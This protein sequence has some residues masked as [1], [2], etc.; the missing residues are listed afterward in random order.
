MKRREFLK[1]TGLGALGL[2][3]R[4]LAVGGQPM[5][6]KPTPQQ[7]AWQEAELT[8]FLTFGMNTFTNREWGEGT[9]DPS[10]FN[11]S[12]LDAGQWASVAKEAGL[13]YLILVAKHHDGLCLWPSEFTEHSVKASPWRGG[14]GD[15]VRELADACRHER[16]KMGIY[17][18][19]WD[20]NC[21]VYG[22]PAYNGH[23]KNQLTELLTNYGEIAEVWF[24]GACGEGPNGKK[25][26]Y[27][28][29]GYYDVIRKL[30]PSALIAICGPDIRWVGNEDG[31]ARETEWSVQ[32]ADPVYHKGI[33]GKVWWPAECDVSIR[34][35]WFWH[36]AE[37]DKVKSLDHLMDIY[38]KSVGRNSV[39][40]LNV[41]PNDRGLI[42]EPD[43][44]RL[45]EFRRGLDKTFADDLAKGK[46]AHA[47]STYP[48]SRASYAVDGKPDTHWSP[49]LT[50]GWLEVD[51]GKP[52]AFDV[53]MVQEQISEGQR[54]EEYRIEAQT[55]QGW[56]E[57]A[58]GTTIGHKKLD[59][60]SPVT[61]TRVRLT[62]IRSQAKPLIRRLGLFKR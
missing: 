55:D 2:M 50:S 11:P 26:E 14:N 40:L 21:P 46:K 41:P 34:P 13:K 12:S 54:V 60:F 9:E 49:G 45:Q 1:V 29:P 47:D 37:D 25:Q 3:S 22:S 56:V 59:R 7:L 48:A 44:Q 39:L 57:V 17:L 24:D 15:V 43:I 4:S 61:A 31:F 6:V 10:L 32:D 62:I 16:L 27:D 38:F 51:L 52:V 42:S 18:S 58:K 33:E 5:T 35:G 19:P 36:R 28:F 30:Q 8:M 53:S 20:R 23:F